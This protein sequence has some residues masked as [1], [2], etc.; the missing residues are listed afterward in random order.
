MTETAITHTLYR[1]YDAAGNLLYVGQTISPSK[2]WRDHERKAPWYPNVATVK[3][4]VFETAAEVDRAERDAIATESPIHN[5]MLNPNRRR[6]QAEVALRFTS[7]VYDIARRWSAV[8]IDPVDQADA[9]CDGDEYICECVECH[10]KRCL[11]IEHAYS[12]Y[13]WHPAINAA[14]S[15]AEEAYFNGHDLADW[16]YELNDAVMFGQLHILEESKRRPLPASAYVDG[17]EAHV[18]CPFCI[19][20]HRHFLVPGQPL[21]KPVE[22]GCG[23]FAGGMYVMHFDLLDAMDEQRH[24]ADAST[25]KVAS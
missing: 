15:A 4:Q 17:Q 22:S 5:V 3:R 8:G 10:E 24:W 9:G 21:D 25:L 2:R 11:E 23:R 1:F 14:I 12:S 19:Q 13:E 7:G 6:S 16:Y 18:D 20:V